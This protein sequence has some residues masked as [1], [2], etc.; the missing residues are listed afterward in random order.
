M[1]TQRGMTLIELIVAMS[2][3]VTLGGALV[4]FL[5]V[6]VETWRVGEMRREAYERSQAILDA[7]TDD[8]ASAFSDPEHGAEGQVDVRFFADTDHAGRQRLRFVR[9]LAGEM[10]H[11][12]TQQAGS[13]TGGQFDYDYINDAMEMEQGLLRAPGGLMEIA[14]FMDPVAASS[15]T[16]GGTS[17]VLWRAVKSPIGGEGSLFE[18]ANIY[19]YPEGDDALPMGT[20]RARPLAAGVLY[21]EC[22]YWGQETQTWTSTTEPGGRAALSWWDSTRAITRPSDVEKGDAAY[23]DPASLHDFRDDIF[24]SA[25]QITLVLRPARAT[26]L[27]RLTRAIAPNDTEIQ[28]D[29]T[30]NYP[31]G[32]FQY[33]RIGDEWIR[34]G[35]KSERRFLAC[36]RAQRGTTAA[37]SY[38]SGTPVIYGS[39]FSRVARI[40]TARQSGWGR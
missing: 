17:D 24:P 23:F 15:P 21:F 25:V 38:P 33:I 31:D 10:R 2:I 9:T 5:R 37:P 34:Y 1:K 26:R 22:R 7:L 12:I 28:V 35:S 8:L 36:E 20:R 4:M 32:A 6:G 16:G 11:P 14:Y 3:F 40:P 29:R 30:D 39:T 27:A 18:D 19:E 13:L